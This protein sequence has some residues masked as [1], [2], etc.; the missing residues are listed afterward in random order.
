[1]SSYK[2]SCK[3]DPMVKVLSIYHIYKL[4]KT[5]VLSFIYNF[6]SWNSKWLSKWVITHP[7]KVPLKFTLIS[8]FFWVKLVHCSK[9]HQNSTQH[10]KALTN[11][12]CAYVT[13]SKSW[14]LQI[15]A[16]DSYFHKFMNTPF[17]SLEHV[18]RSWEMKPTYIYVLHVL[19]NNMYCT[20]DF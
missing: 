15:T 18:K 16:F 19:H 8:K 12:V 20:A 4:R 3:R 2:L 11:R 9:S 14:S 7:Q 17:R 5:E 13:Y 1:M 6:W 10:S